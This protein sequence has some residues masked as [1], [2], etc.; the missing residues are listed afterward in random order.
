MPKPIDPEIEGRI[1][2][3]AAKLWTQGGEKAV[4]MRKVAV[5]AKTSTPTI[6]ERFPNKKALMIA[7][8]EL[9]NTSFLKYLDSAKSSTVFFSKYIDFGES[10]PRQYEFLFGPGWKDR[11]NP[12]NMPG[13]VSRLQT[14]LEKE[15]NSSEQ[16][17]KKGLAFAIWTLLHGTVML[18]IVV[19]KPGKNWP[20][21]KRSCLKGC[22]I[23]KKSDLD[24]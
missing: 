14:V 4:S 9:A 1:L 11:R 12:E 5:E 7:I 22:E 8:R 15:S 3:G 2:K 21:V 23:L 17:S 10:N 6:Y 20:L 16:K 13:V 18:R 19:K 24:D